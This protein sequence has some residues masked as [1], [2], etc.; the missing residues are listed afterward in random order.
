MAEISC[1]AP[2]GRG[3]KPRVKKNAFRLDMTPM[4]DLAFLLL[5][6]FMLTSTFAKPSVMELTMPAK[7]DK[8]T[9]GPDWPA[10]RVMTLI[11]GKDS[12][13]H[14][15]FGLNDPDARPTLRTTNFS[16]EGL[17]HV[18]LQRQRQQP[19]PFV[20]I[21]AGPDAKYRDLVDVL[22]EMNITD[23]GKYALVDFTPADEE[24]LKRNAL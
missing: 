20:L 2:T 21:K 4:V 19:E 5:T 10:S 16:A 9:I 17:R 23:Q 24:L 7:P 3:H 15:F 8:N 1:S 12:R 18:L 14:Y 11:L 6:F 22:D 13:V